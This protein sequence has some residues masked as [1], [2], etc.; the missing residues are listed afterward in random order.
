MNRLIWQNT[1]ITLPNIN[2]VIK[3][4]VGTTS[5]TDRPERAVTTAYSGIKI[6]LNFLKT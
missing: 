4:E 3:H 2:L 6:I 5:T 1:D